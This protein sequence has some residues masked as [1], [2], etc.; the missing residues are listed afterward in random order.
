MKH[1]VNID[2]SNFKENVL[3]LEANTLTV[4][5]GNSF[6]AFETNLYNAG[7]MVRKSS[8]QS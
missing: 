2:L 4:G 1:A 7:K 8:L 5:P 6:S 3:D